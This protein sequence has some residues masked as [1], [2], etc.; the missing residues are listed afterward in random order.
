MEEKE[1]SFALSEEQRTMKETVARLMKDLVADRAHEMDEKKAIPDG[2][3]QKIW[4][5]A[6]YYLSFPKNSGAMAWNI[7][8]S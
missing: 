5:W 2:C 3:I 4:S 8:R 1:F 6:G 7:P